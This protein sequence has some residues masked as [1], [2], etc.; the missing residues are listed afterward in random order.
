MWQCRVSEMHKMWRCLIEPREEIGGQSPQ[1][2]QIKYQKAVGSDSNRI[3]ISCAVY[4][5][6][7]VFQVRIHILRYQVPRKKDPT[8]PQVCKDSPVLPPPTKK[9]K[10]YSWVIIH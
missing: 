8:T 5:I 2:M 9:F 7:L 4:R 10:P 1:C 6:E 3:L